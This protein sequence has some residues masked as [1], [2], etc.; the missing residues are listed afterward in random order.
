MARLAVLIAFVVLAALANS[1]PVNDSSRLLGR[2]DL[3]SSDKF[4]EYMVALGVDEATRKVAVNLKQT[5]VISRDGD[6][7]TI[8]MEST[9]RNT[10]LKFTEGVEFEENRLDGK[11]CK[12]TVTVEGPNK[13][14]QVEKD[15]ETGKVLSTITREV[16]DKDEMVTT[17]TAGEVTCTRVYKRV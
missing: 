9:V 5:N 17:L 16:N 11:K 15:H 12:S 7:W 1:T 8:R 2:W 6:M 10:E 4:E 14:V 13:L 3:H